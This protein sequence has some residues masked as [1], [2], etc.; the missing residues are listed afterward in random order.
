MR[1][2]YYLVLDQAGEHKE[3]AGDGGGCQLLPHH[4]ELLHDEDA[5][6]PAILENKCLKAPP[7]R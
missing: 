7:V 1:G 3:E 6:H 2:E 4:V 5:L